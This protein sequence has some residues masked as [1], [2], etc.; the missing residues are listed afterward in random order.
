MYFAIGIAAVLAV[1][2]YRC[3]RS[4]VGKDLVVQM[5]N[6]ADHESMRAAE[7]VAVHTRSEIVLAAQDRFVRAR[8]A[9][10]ESY[11][12]GSA[13]LVTHRWVDVQMAK[14]AFDHSFSQDELSRMAYDRV[15]ALYSGLLAKVW[16]HPARAIKIYPTVRAKVDTIIANLVADYCGFNLGEEERLSLLPGISAAERARHRKEIDGDDFF[17]KLARH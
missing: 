1:V 8:D 2:G 17:Q 15:Q 5:R 7:A 6:E 16:S 14:E 11:C 3:W 10:H 13:E 4:S 9:M 12:G